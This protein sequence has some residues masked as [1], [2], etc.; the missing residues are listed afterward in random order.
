MF[1][2]SAPSYCS[3]LETLTKGEHRFEGIINYAS[4]FDTSLKMDLKQA[5]IYS[6]S[7]PNL[8]RKSFIWRYSNEPGFS[9]FLKDDNYELFA[10]VFCCPE[11]CCSFPLL[12]KSV[13]IR[14]F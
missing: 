3:L 10:M 5:P 13:I 6:V 7:V 1:S 4:S 2:D 9:E 11:A 8:P 12:P 14:Y